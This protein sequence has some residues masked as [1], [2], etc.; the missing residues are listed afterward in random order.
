MSTSLPRRAR[1]SVSANAVLLSDKVKSCVESAEFLH[2]N[3]DTIRA[4]YKIFQQ[5][6]RNTLTLVDSQGEQSRLTSDQE[7]KLSTWLENRFA[8]SRE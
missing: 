7:A 3:D 5:Q 4:W 8:A 2:L 1:D 6:G